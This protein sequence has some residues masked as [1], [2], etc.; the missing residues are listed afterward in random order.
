VHRSERTDFRKNEYEAKIYTDTTKSGGF[1]PSTSRLEDPA[2][3]QHV[4]NTRVEDHG[5]H[6]KPKRLQDSSAAR[7]PQQL[8]DDERCSRDEAVRQRGGMGIGFRKGALDADPGGE[9]IEEDAGPDSD[10]PFHGGQP[11]Q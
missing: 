10:Q 8:E 6:Q 2:Q 3:H 11:N 9:V 5:R 4:V 7:V 1:A